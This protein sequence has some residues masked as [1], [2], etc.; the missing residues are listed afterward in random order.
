MSLSGRRG[1]H[2]LDIWPGFVDALASLLMVLIFVLMVFVLAQ[3]FL[4]EMLSGRETGAAAIA[5]AGQR[6]RRRARSRASGEERAGPGS[7]APDRRTARFAVG[8]R[9]AGGTGAGPRG[10][11]GSSGRAGGGAE[12]GYDEARERHCR[13]AGTEGGTGTGGGETGTTQRAGRSGTYRGAQG[14]GERAGPTRAAQPAD[15]GASRADRASWRRRSTP[16]KR[17]RPNSKCRSPPSV[18]G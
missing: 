5:G 13:A 4:S 6:T 15:G 8:T 10:A 3:F 17:R 7:R 16:R 9:K 12:W 18:S 11:C 2:R 14:F 1:A